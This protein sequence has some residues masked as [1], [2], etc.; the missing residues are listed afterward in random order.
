MFDAV[1][2]HISRQS[3]WFQGFLAG[4]PEYADWF[5]AFEPDDPQDWVPLVVRP[6]PCPC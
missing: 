6:R 4:D 3:E 5:I 1:I 2:N